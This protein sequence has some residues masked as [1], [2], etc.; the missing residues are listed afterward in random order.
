MKALVCLTFAVSLASHACA[1]ETVL[2]AG[3]TGRTGSVLIQSLK[4]QG[5]TV[6]A[7]ARDVEDAKKELGE[8]YDWVKADIRSKSDVAAAFQGTTIDYVIS[9]IGSRTWIGA[10]SPQFVDYVGTKN[11]AEAAAQAKVKHFVVVSVGNIGPHVDQTREPSFGYLQYWK[12]KGEDAVKASGIPYTIVGPGGLVERPAGQQA[13]KL[14]ARKDYKRGQISIADSAMVAV[15]A[16]KNPDA[17]N[18]SF[19][20]INVDGAPNED[21]KAVLQT[22]PVEKLG[23]PPTVIDARSETSLE[24]LD[25]AE[26]PIRRFAFTAYG[27]QIRGQEVEIPDSGNMFCA[28]SNVNS[29]FLNYFPNAKAWKIEMLHNDDR[30]ALAGAIVTCHRLP[31]S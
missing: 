3:A 22:M 9:A 20:I 5:Y 23:L 30:N 25:P 19:G 11:L 28:L 18:K 10:N 31:G 2:V 13:I 6:R 21:W 14:T 15:D 4:S 17:R 7:L 24:A 1:A 29:T 16:L 12:T 26:A 8:G 27:T